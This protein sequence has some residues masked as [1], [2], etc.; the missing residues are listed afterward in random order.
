MNPLTFT[1]EHS[2]FIKVDLPPGEVVRGKMVPV[3][4]TVH[5]YL[6]HQIEVRF[7]LFYS[8]FESIIY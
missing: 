3:E 1:V 6:P 8:R 7:L 2:L 5:N 4:V